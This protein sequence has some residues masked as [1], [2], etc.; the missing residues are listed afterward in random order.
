MVYSL[1]FL[2][3]CS[4]DDISVGG[5]LTVTDANLCLG[6][7][8]PRYMCTNCIWFVG[9]FFLLLFWHSTIL[10]INLCVVEICK[11][12]L[13]SL[14]QVHSLCFCGFN[15]LVDMVYAPCMKS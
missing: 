8:L 4:L 2:I 11:V 10:N 7:L 1:S 5:P 12:E 3:M 13:Y 9:T 14:L 6:R 15:I